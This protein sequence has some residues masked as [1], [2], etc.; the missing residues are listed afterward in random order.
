MESGKRE[1][2][3]ILVRELVHREMR[4]L[5]QFFTK[6]V[7]LMLDAVDEARDP[8]PTARREP[9][10]YAYRY[11]WH[12]GGTVLRFNGG[13]EVNGS[14]PMESVPY[15]LGEQPEQPND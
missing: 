14:K 3:Q 9:D 12:T 11:P 15:W 8:E 13:E 6:R 1:M 10:G 4:L 7:M 5:E 2:L